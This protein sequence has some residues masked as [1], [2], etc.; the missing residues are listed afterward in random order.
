MKTFVLEEYTMSNITDVK[1]RIIELGPAEFQEFCDSFL[2]KKGY[3]FVLGYGMQSGTGQTTIGNP[4]T[5]FRK[6]N[7]KYYFVAYTTQKQNIYTKLLEDINKCLDV[8]KT[9]VQVE[10]IEE[11]I[12]C[13]TSSNLSAGNDQKLYDYC[14]NKGIKLTIYGVDEI[15]NQVCSQYRSLIKDGLGLS[16][17][18]NQILSFDDFINQY[19]ANGMSAPLSTSFQYRTKEKDEITEALDEKSV[20]IITG[21]AGVGKTRLVLESIKEYAFKNGYKL[22]CVKSN[23]LGIYEDLVSATE[24]PSRYLFFIDDANELAELNLILGYITKK[25]LGFNVKIIATVR[26][27]VKANVISEVKKYEIPKI[28]EVMPF[29][30]EEIKG[31][32]GENLGI[33]NPEYVNKIVAIAEGNPRIAYMAGKLAKEKNN[34]SAIS[35]VSQLYEAYYRKYVDESIGEDI[36]LCFT[37]GILAIVNAVVLD[38]FVFFKE[39]LENQGIDE[40]EFKNSIIQL[41]KL[42]VVEIQLDKVATLADQCFANYMLYY[43]FFQK[44]IISLGDVLEIG[45]KYFKNGVIRSVNTIL[46]IFETEETRN[47]CKQE[48]LRA[49]KNLEKCKDIN[50]TRFVQDFHVFNPEAGFL[51]AKGIID[52]L[53]YEEFDAK[54]VDFKQNIFN[55]N[56]EPLRLLEGYNRSNYIDYVI[57]LLIDYCEKSKE[58]LVTGY[59]WLEN[60]YG[61]NIDSYK[62]G[63][64]TQIKV[65][66]NLYNAAKEG[67]LVAM[68]LGG[69]WAKY[70]LNFVFRPTKFER[71]NKILIY[72]YEIKKTPGV[73]EYRQKC[74]EILLLL[75]SKTEWQNVVTQGINHYSKILSGLNESSIFELDKKFVEECLDALDNNDL[76][77]LIG[78]E[79]LFLNVEK[80]GVNFDKKWKANFKGKK[81]ELY[82]LLEEDYIHSE[83]E[84]KDYIKYREERIIEYAKQLTKNNISDLVRYSNEILAELPIDHN[85]YSINR[86]IELIIQQL[87]NE[88]LYEFLNVFI[89]KGSNLSINALTVLGPLNENGDSEILLSILKEKEFPQKNEWLFAFFESLPKYAVNEYYY[90][91]FIIFLESDTDKGITSS[92]YRRLRVL[93]KFIIINPNIYPI[94]CSIIYAKTK[95]NSF[96]VEIYFDIL[97][98]DNVYS[99]YELIKLFES[100]LEL[101]KDIYFWSLSM[102][103]LVDYDGA[104]L[105]VFIEIDESWLSKYS[106]LFWDN[107]INNLNED[108]NRN[109]V[110]WESGKY[111]E[112]FDSIFDNFPNDII[113]KR[114]NVV[115]FS[116]ML[117]IS[118]GDDVVKKHQQEWLKYQIIKN[119]HS[120][121]IKVLFDIVLELNEEIRR[122]AIE[123]F[124]NNNDDYELFKELNLLPMHWSGTNSLVPAYQKQIDFLVS[125]YPYVNGVKF[126]KHK[127][128]IQELID[129]LKEMIKNEEVEAICR[130]LYM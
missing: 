113:Y 105:S 88:C 60:N 103:R 67:K 79:K 58:M 19:D 32:I 63:Y 8:E 40:E 61:I 23:N 108:Y 35:D 20:V 124:L 127:M 66:E 102:G 128:R 5:Y 30:D 9:G 114:S 56:E 1:R 78:V 121:K 62:Y 92:G 115:K 72:N 94:A 116:E 16:I 42:E 49:W 36:N 11:I 106:E 53:R 98:N 55:V 33:K 101:L 81:W 4:D 107:K 48:V 110:L 129:Y 46:E 7:G 75:A 2:H 54:T 12:C 123:V 15:A 122:L 26:D 65:G 14:K 68:A 71:D 52:S 70:A 83:L 45:Y 69:Q 76:S 59:K 44:K 51:I 27:Y 29:T 3:G 41:A 117:L 21:K 104:F 111:I 82:K 119:A 43:V 17:D 99:P 18:T 126:L 100:N 25:Y 13:H 74:W 85:S 22:F 95:Y 91:E 96:M 130:H 125:L 24:Q 84:Y 118:S 38:N 120:E 47:Y 39:L 80:L 86:G 109:R 28:I 73:E 90:N 64:Y 57:D 50:Y 112:Y 6:E 77:F 97:F 89:E 10:D 31:F 34:I 87:D 37:A 93:D